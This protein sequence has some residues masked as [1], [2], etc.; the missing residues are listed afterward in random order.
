[1]KATAEFVRR[2]YKIKR[3]EGD[4][5]PKIEGEKST[6]WIAID[7]GNIAL[8]IFEKQTREKYDIEMLWSVGADYDTQNNQVGDDPFADLFEKHSEVLGRYQ[9]TSESTEAEKSN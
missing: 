1:M 6:E 3:A 9:E 5:I 7:L 8:H 2:M 4:I